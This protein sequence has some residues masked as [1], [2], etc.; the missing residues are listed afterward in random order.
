MG[1]CAT[2]YVPNGTPTADQVSGDCQ[3][4]QCNGSGSV[5]VSVPDDTDV[6]GGGGSVVYACTA[7]ACAVPRAGADRH[8]L[9]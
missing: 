9:R 7:G 8:G 2:Q 5:F 3:Q 1:A 4:T 6:P